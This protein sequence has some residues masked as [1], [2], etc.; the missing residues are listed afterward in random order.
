MPWNELGK[1]LCDSQESERDAL[2]ERES[3]RGG[4]R[5]SQEATAGKERCLPFIFILGFSSTS[6]HVLIF[7]PIKSKILKRLPLLPKARSPSPQIFT[8]FIHNRV[9]T[10]WLSE[11]VPTWIC[12][13]IQTTRTR[14]SKPGPDP[15]WIRTC[16]NVRIS[17]SDIK[18]VSIPGFFRVG[19]PGIQIGQFFV[20][21]SLNPWNPHIYGLD[22]SFSER[23]QC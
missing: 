4:E 9:R 7:S 21:P 17:N 6:I 10:V 13:H 3:E 23:R 1:P 2:E 18:K 20:S 22:H 19:N 16:P 12:L 8:Y 11:F 15:V 14:F 5:K